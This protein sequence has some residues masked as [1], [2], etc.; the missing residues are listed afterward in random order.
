MFGDIL[1][2]WVSLTANDLPA[3]ILAELRHMVERFRVTVNR[4]VGLHLGNP[5]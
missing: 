2:E 1:R 3:F 4:L 5:G